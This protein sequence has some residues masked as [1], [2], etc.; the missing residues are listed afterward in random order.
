MNR[1]TYIIIGIIAAL[2]AGIGIFLYLRKK[3]VMPAAG[4]TG[5]A[6]G[7]VSTA[8]EGFD[9]LRDIANGNQTPPVVVG[10]N[11]RV[12]SVEFARAAPLST[13]GGPI[14]SQ[15]PGGTPAPSSGSSSS[16][17]ISAG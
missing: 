4:S 3:K 1:K 6:T 7:K 12:Q 17:G 13:S 5:A 16:G 10:T 11:R 9:T 2:I 14:I 15:P 8:N